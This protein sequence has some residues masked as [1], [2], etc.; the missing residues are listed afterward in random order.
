MKQYCYE[1]DWR[2]YAFPRDQSGLA[3]E[4]TMEERYTAV[5]LEAEGKLEKGG[6]PVRCDGHRALINTENEHTLIYGSTASKKTRTLILPLLP[7]LAQAG[8]SMIV[9]DIKGE[10][11]DGIRFPEIRGMLE[12]RGYTCR[13]LNLRDKNGDGYNIMLEP[14]RLLRAGQWDEAVRM[15]NDNVDALAAIYRDSQADPFWEKTARLYLVAVSM[16]LL[17]MCPDERKIN[18]LSL[19]SY[20][21][22]NGSENMLRVADALDFDNHI[23]AMLRSV[24]SEPERTRMST[25]ATVSSMMTDF[26]TDT[27][28]LRMLSHST[29]EIKDLYREPTALFVIVPDEVDT[30]AGITGLILQQI[31]SIL[32]RAAHTL[33]GVLPRRVNMVCDEFCNYYIPGMMRSI[34]AHRS[35]NIRWYLVCQSRRQL[36]ACYPKEADTIIANCSNIYFLNSPELTLLEDLSRRSGITMVTHDSTPKPVISVADLQGLKKEWDQ[37]E[38][39]FT[40]GGIH[41]VTALP[42]I[43]RYPY[44]QGY[45][46]PRPMPERT[47]P[48]PAV[49]SAQQM[50]QDAL[51]MRAAHEAKVSGKKMEPGMKKYADQYESL[52]PKV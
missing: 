48:A 49:Y 28:L 9:L 42:D 44:L 36:E 17:A 19:A 5:T 2:Q 10:L 22:W 35:R 33:G 21:D 51:R 43:S 13:F 18:M 38:V 11:S 40:S 37:T 23:I 24:V 47:F 26:L 31:N 46:E 8:E 30:Y 52:F 15:I 14:Y 3:S 6:M 20:T 39:Y 1:S 41:Y 45:R 25:L 29:F 4:E 16:L 32:V 50:C 12:S 34:S 27:K 7:I